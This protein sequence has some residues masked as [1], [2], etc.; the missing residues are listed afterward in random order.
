[1][2]DT[3]KG[4]PVDGKDTYLFDLEITISNFRTM[5]SEDADKLEL[6]LDLRQLMVIKKANDIGTE[7]VILQTVIGMDGDVTTRISKAFA[8]QPVTFI[9]DMHH[10][11][12]GISVD[13][14]KSLITVVVELGKNFMGMFTSKS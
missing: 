7:K 3:V 8:N 2:V 13:F 4:I 6:D 1:M 12:I 14:W 5:R 11:A 10:E 9:N